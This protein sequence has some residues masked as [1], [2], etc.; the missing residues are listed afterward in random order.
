[1]SAQDSEDA[2]RIEPLDYH[3]PCHPH[4]QGS[5]AEDECFGLYREPLLQ[6][7]ECDHART[8]ETDFPGLGGG[9]YQ[10]ICLDCTAVLDVEDKQEVSP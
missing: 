3:Q 5:P 4:L 8:R 7:G 2:L 9:A 10:T 1:M 6:E